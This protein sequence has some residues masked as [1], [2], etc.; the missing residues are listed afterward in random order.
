MLLLGFLALLSVVSGR[1]QTPYIV[2]A[3]AAY[4]T[5]VA[6]LSGVV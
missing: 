2:V 4:G 6:V 1:S 3:L 5:A